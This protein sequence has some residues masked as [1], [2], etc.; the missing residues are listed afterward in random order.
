MTIKQRIRCA[1][2]TRKSHEDRL[3]QDFNSLTAQ[4]EACLAYIASQKSEGW[5]AV[6]T[7]YDDGGFSGGTLERP[8]V[9]RLLADIDA[10]KI[11]VVVV[12]KVDRLTRSL[13]DF[14]KIVELLDG[15]GAS[16]VS[17]TQ[18]FNTTSSM[19]RLTLNV[20]LSFAQFEREV[21]GERIRDKI[22]ASKAKGMWM[23]GLV[24]LGYDA[25]VEGAPRSLTVNLKEAEI[26]RH[27]FTRYLELGSVH[28]LRDELE[29]TGVRSKSRVMK[30]GQPSGGQAFSRGALFHLLKN[31]IYRGLIPHKGKT[32]AGLHAAII[33]EEV[34]DA[35]QR[36]LADNAQRR[37]QGPTG[38]G[39]SLLKGLLYD[40]GGA[41]MSPTISYGKLKRAYRYYV[42]SPLQCGKGQ[43]QSPDHVRRVAAAAIESLVSDALRKALGL[44][45]AV[46]W[47]ALKVLL[48]RVELKARSVDLLLDAH[49]GVDLDQVTARSHG[50]AT[51][52]LDGDGHRIR[53]SVL[54][55][56]EFRGGRT[57]IVGEGGYHPAK[58]SRVDAKLVKALKSAH[59]WQLHLNASP[60]ST[61]TDL[62]AAKVHPDSYIRQLGYLAF[63]APD[64]Q[65][66]I[67]DGHQPAGLTVRRLLTSKL[68]LDWAAQRKLL[69]FAA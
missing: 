46:D 49:G 68:P 61:P 50:W 25:P 10:G 31:P 20:L 42:S 69:G 17:V 4:R 34:F 43:G 59:A 53:L 35:V 41:P 16:F 66:A 32:F 65:Q 40:E 51:I 45:E 62:A 14:S 7:A 6:V 58:S 36:S 38:P 8:A 63:L 21:T 26:V 44:S 30:S 15:K 3:E 47:D 52:N 24:P 13:S 37:K 54:G 12:Y 29:A 33:D 48:V 9:K 5:G 27:I 11:D 19:G 22:A 1:V 18:A 57:W 23:G 28:A 64:I 67:L 60:L 56:A 2:Y 55:R 39:T